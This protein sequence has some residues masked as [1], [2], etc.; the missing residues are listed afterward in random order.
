[1][2][3]VSKNEFK[4][5]IARRGTN[6]RDFCKKYNLNYVIFNQALNG[7]VKMRIEYENAMGVFMNEPQQTQFP[8][9]EEGSDGSSEEQNS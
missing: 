3:N 7:F 4:S 5:E 9:M 2:N 6:Q 1:M 8:F